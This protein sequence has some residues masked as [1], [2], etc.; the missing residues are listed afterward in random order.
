MPWI[1][2]LKAQVAG[3][4]DTLE[5]TFAREK[6]DGDVFAIWERYASVEAWK[7]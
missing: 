5:Y 7:K 1:T 4:K 3:E 6:P 2:K